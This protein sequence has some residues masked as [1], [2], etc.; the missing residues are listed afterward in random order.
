MSK[1]IISVSAWFKCDLD[2]TKFVNTDD[3]DKQI[4]DGNEY[5]LLSQDERD[6]YI[7]ES[8]WTAA[9]NSLDGDIV[10][11]TIDVEND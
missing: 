9:Q 8:C 4:I 7:L 10:D 2:D 5:V 3:S 1:I 6:K 11:L